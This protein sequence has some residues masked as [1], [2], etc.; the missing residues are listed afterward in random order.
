MPRPELLQGS[1]KTTVSTCGPT[2]VGSRGRERILR[3]TKLLHPPDVSLPPAALLELAGYFASVL[4]SQGYRVPVDPMLSQD[5]R[6]CFDISFHA[7]QRWHDRM[8]EAWRTCQSPFSSFI[9]PEITCT[10]SPW[11]DIDKIERNDVRMCSLACDC[12][13]GICV[14]PAHARSRQ[15]RRNPFADN[16]N[17]LSLH[18]GPLSVRAVHED[19]EP[20]MLIA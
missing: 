15:V 6:M 3:R 19:R 11:N 9:T 5:W 13:S 1:P 16:S 8:L 14:A 7:V 17:F 4:R 10:P 12:W 20:G 18:R 2:T